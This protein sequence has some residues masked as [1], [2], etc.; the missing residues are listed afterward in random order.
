[1]RFLSF[2]L[3]SCVCYWTQ[4]QANQTPSSLDQVEK[5]CISQ[6]Q[7]YKIVPGQDFVR[8]ELLVGLLVALGFQ[9]SLSN[10]KLSFSLSNPKLSLSN[11]K[12]NKI[13]EFAER[14][15]QAVPER[16]VPPLLLRAAPAGGERGKSKSMVYGSISLYLWH[17]VYC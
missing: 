1:M 17:I 12:L 9:I 6:R 7:K 14:D 15:A 4:T 11:P 13:G 8:R 5:W 2:I 3:L 10:P 16:E